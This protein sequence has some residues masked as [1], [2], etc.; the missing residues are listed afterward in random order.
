[1]K[2]DSSI[3]SDG[4]LKW[5]HGGEGVLNTIHFQITWKVFCCHTLIHVHM[6]I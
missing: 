4:G 2:E 6:G 3:V 1:M 5:G